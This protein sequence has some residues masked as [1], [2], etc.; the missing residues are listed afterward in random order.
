MPEEVKFTE[1]QL[2]QVQKDTKKLCIQKCSQINLD[3]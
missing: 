1:E 2:K 3:N